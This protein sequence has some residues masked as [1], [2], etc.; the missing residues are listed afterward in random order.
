MVGVGMMNWCPPGGQ[1]ESGM[2]ERMHIGEVYSVS[3]G[4]AMV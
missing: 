1:R 3:F 2:R 4:T